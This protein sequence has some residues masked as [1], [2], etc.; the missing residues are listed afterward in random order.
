MFK[1]SELSKTLWRVGQG[2]RPQ[3]ALPSFP[4]L[5]SSKEAA[6]IDLSTSEV[7]M[8]LRRPTPQ[9]YGIR[10]APEP[11][12]SVS[13]QHKDMILGMKGGRA[14]KLRISQIMF[15]PPGRMGAWNKK[16]QFCLH[17]TRKK[18]LHFFHTKSVDLE[19][20]LLYRK[21]Y[22]VFLR[23][24]LYNHPLSSLLRLSFPKLP[25]S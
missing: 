1:K 9:R 12:N 17:R 3:R 11:H 10:N 18:K 4:Q 20:C 24:F 5:W 8:Q 6:S 7:Q 2:R 15:I 14:M 13:S 16:R 25:S 19:L 23:R 22:E 21:H